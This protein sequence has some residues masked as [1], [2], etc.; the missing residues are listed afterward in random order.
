MIFYAL[1]ELANQLL[2]GVNTLAVCEALTMSRR[3]GVDLEKLLEILRNA[4]GQSRMLERNAPTI[5]DEDYDRPGA[6]LRNIVKDLS[7]ICALGGDL[8]LRLD[9]A[10]TSLAVFRELEAKGL[11]ESDM[12]SACRAVARE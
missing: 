6:P 10:R 12:S 4:W 9:G 5:I 8:D 7:I 3:A 1:E 11:G 2:V